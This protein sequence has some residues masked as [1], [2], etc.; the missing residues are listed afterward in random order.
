MN[1]VREIVSICDKHEGSGNIK[2]VFMCDAGG[3]CE[4][5]PGF[6][7]GKQSR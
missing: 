2:L 7:F 3:T 4:P 5:V 6:L 1:Q